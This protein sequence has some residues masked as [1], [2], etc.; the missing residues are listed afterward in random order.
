MEIANIPYKSISNGAKILKPNYHLN[1]GKKRIEKA[2]SLKRPFSPLGQV[3]DDVYTG[4]IFKRVFIDSENHGLPYISA[5]HMMHARP[6]EVAKLI[7][8]KF[9]PRQED[10]TLRENQILVSC[11]GTV[12][13]VRLIGAD[14][15]GIIG[16]QDIIRIIPSDEKCKFGFLYAYLASPTAYNYMQ[17]FIYGSVVPRIEPQT[18]SLLPVPILE[19]S[20]ITK[21][22]QLIR[23]SLKARNSAIKALNEALRLFEENL[24]K[25]NK[26]ANYSLSI[27]KL[28]NYRN[29]FESTLQIN[30][31][32][33]YH[34]ELEKRGYT[35]KYIDELSDDVFTPNIFKRIKVDKSNT[36][37]PYL[38]GA[39]LLTLSPKFDTFLSRNTKNINDYLLRKGYIAVQDSGSIQSMGYVSMIPE[40][41]KGIAATNNLVRI[42]PSSNQDFNP[43]IFAYLKTKQANS[44]IKNMAYG[45]GQLHIDTNIIKEFKIPVIE[46]LF[47]PVTT[48]VKSY[49]SHLER[50][51]S[52]EK[53]AIDIVENEIESWQKS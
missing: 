12:G 1:Y 8:K 3:V 52:L 28:S 49:L 45:T 32:N 34:T 4:G 16:S 20:L 13:N 41:L 36:S 48:A 30:S 11:A 35:L 24:P 50:G 18:L 39:D 23:E 10:M 26:R 40:Y 47:K 43:Y 15:D 6:L 53:N 38:G 46:K 2:L 51:Y 5:Q 19:Q 22:D 44:I 17:S 25:I 9:T 31:L 27:N 29:R 37:I 7:S 21:C 42:V 33:E 14:L